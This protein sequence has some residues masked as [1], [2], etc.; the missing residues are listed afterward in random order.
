MSLRSMRAELLDL[1]GMRF[2]EKEWPS[3]VS[4]RELADFT[5]EHLGKAD[6]DPR[7]Q[8]A[9]HLAEEV[10]RKLRRQK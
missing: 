1:L 6:V 4:A 7:S 8:R 2:P 5:L 10:K 9:L 3:L